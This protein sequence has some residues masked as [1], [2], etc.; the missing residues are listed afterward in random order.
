MYGYLNALCSVR[1][2]MNDV[3]KKTFLLC[4]NS[5]KTNS[6]TSVLLQAYATDHP[7]AQ[8]FPSHLKQAA[9]YFQVRSILII[10]SQ[11]RQLCECYFIF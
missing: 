2:S 4:E 9:D 3:S 10:I 8:Y 6:V 1:I 7:F 11:I 5:I